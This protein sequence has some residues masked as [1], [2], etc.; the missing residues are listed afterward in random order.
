MEQVCPLC[1]GLREVEKKC[2]KC[3]EKMLDGGRIQDYYAPYSPYL[4]ENLLS[5]PK[6]NM[7]N[8]EGLCIHLLYCPN[9]GKDQRILVNE[10]YI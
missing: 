5:P 1:N 10:L 8:S 9:C 6:V 7:E 3:G 4:D 2:P